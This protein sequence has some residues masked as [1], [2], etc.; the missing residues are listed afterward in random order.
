MTKLIIDLCA[1]LGG[2]SRAFKNDSEWEVITLEIEK[3]FKPTILADVRHLPLRPNLQPD[4]LLASP[5]CERFSIACRTWPKMGLMKAMEIVGACFEAVAYLKPKKWLVEN[6][7]GR[8]RWFLG[9]P[10]MTVRLVDYGAPYEK[11]TDLWGNIIL[12]MLL[13]K[14]EAKFWVLQEGTMHK[15]QVSKPTVNYFIHGTSGSGN[16]KAKRAEMPFGLSQAILEV[17]K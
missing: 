10:P 3:K 12:P 17:C 6:P 1:G 14:K 13:E 15:N 5:P 9:K 16:G 2:F 7:M 11:K 8:L 4:C